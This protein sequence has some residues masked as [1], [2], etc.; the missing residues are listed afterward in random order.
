[1]AYAWLNPPRCY[2][3]LVPLFRTEVHLQLSC[4]LVYLSMCSIVSSPYSARRQGPW[5]QLPHEV[6]DSL[7]NVNCDPAALPTVRGLLD[8]KS[9][10]NP[11]SDRSRFKSL[12]PAPLPIDMSFLSDEDERLPPPI[13]PAVFRGVGE[14]RKLVDDASELAVRA[15]SGM[16][17]AALGAFNLSNSG[18]GSPAEQQGMGSV[19][20]GGK[21]SGRD[22][23]MS[24]VRQHRLRALAVGKLAEAYKIDEI[25]ASVCVMQSATGLD[26]L[27]QRV[28]KYEPESLDAQYVHFFHEKIPSR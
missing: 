19:N 24:P 15:A 25:A 1:M 10:A 22:V 21:G 5:L 6:L 20:G 7:L 14:I 8:A 13:D 4:E 28:L 9:N 3:P 12:P 23:A 18:M 17:A 26:D 11:L 27:A 2:S 16:S